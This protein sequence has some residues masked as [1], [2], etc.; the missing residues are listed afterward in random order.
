MKNAILAVACLIILTSVVGAQHYAIPPYYEQSDFLMASSGVYYDGLLGFANPANLSFLDGSEARYYWTASERSGLSFNDNW[1]LFLAAPHL[2][3]GMLRRHQGNLKST[4]YRISTS[5]GGDHVSLGLGYGWSKAN[6]ESFEGEKIFH[7]GL[8]V[9]PMKYLSV[10]LIGDFS[11]QSEAAQGVAE[12]GVRPFGTRKLT[13]FG[14]FA[15]QNKTR[16][17]DAPWSTGA[18]YEVIP[19]IDVIGRYFKDENFTVG[20]VF[21]LGYGSVAAQSHFNDDQEHQYDNYFI[22]LGDL[23]PSFLPKLVDKGRRYVKID[24]TGSVDYLNYEFFSDDNHQFLSL[25][26]DIKA[27]GEDDRVAVIAVY[28]SNSKIAPELAW[29]IREALKGAQQKGKKVVAFI[30]YTDIR[31]YYLASVADVVVMDPNSLI[32]ITGYAMGKTYLK[33]TLEKLGLGFDEWRFFK[34][35]SAMEVFSRTNFSEPDSEQYQAYIDDW[36]ANTRQGVCE[37]RGITPER[38]DYLIN[39]VA[40]FNPDQALE[41]NLA[42][43]IGRWEDVDRI[44]DQLAD[45]PLRPISSGGLSANA[46]PAKYWGGD[47][48]VAVVYA[49]GE[50]AMYSGIRAVWLG[51][52]LRRLASDRTVKAVV[53][54]VDSPGGDGMASDVVAEALK[55]CARRKPVIVSQGQVAGSGGYWISMYGDKI[56]AGPNTIT[57]SIGVIGGWIWDDGFSKKLGLTSDYVTAGEHADVGYGVRLPIL[58]IMVPARDLTSDEREKVKAMILSFYDQ[59]VDKVAAGRHMS[60][61]RVKEIGQGHFYSG[62]EGKE[63]DLVDDIGGLMM[64]IEMAKQDAGIAADQRVKLIEV[65]QSLGLFPFKKPF[66]TFGLGTKIDPEDPAIRYIKMLNESPIKAIPMLP[67][68]TYPSAQ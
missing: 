67:P 19:G 27:A 17:N 39:D 4:D 44:I 30:E 49:L 24:L 5:M 33:G 32:A 16:F 38:F 46:L 52:Q 53:F 65:P 21:N 55:Y 18:I 13:V 45:K 40:L 64:A 60:V 68:G 57:G 36:Y 14:D 29:E 51:K 22:R 59:F 23:R 8:I 25:L 48:K 41:Y 56:L 10:G 3:F 35:K 43:T 6:N 26:G 61:D 47:P 66:A 15:M 28:M 7:S 58:G 63:I 62:V 11:F 50:C 12:L 42:D 20:L 9:R 1:G 37:S 54:R 2:G 34:Y 31:S